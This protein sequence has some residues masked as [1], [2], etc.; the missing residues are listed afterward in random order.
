MDVL[1][2]EVPIARAIVAAEAGTVE[3]TV[4]SVTIGPAVSGDSPGE[5]AVKKTTARD[6]ASQI[7]ATNG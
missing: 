3:V 6:N 4:N 7:G 1:G 5:Q 2:G